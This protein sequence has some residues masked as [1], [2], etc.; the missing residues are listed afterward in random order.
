M[1]YLKARRPNT[2]NGKSLKG[3]L[4]SL[5]LSTIHKTVTNETN[6][7]IFWTVISLTVILF[8]TVNT[9]LKKT[10]NAYCY[11]NWA[12][13]WVS[14]MVGV[15]VFYV[16]KPKHITFTKPFD[17]FSCAASDKGQRRGN[18]FHD[19]KQ[20]CFTWYIISGILD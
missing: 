7:S 11:N 6:C 5:I 12:W 16:E 15:C 20:D 13:Q 17:F 2:I 18:E 1:K 4:F 19:E 8:S 10:W 9:S 14:F 3:F